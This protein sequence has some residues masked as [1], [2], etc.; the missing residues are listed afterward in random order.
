MISRCL[1][2]VIRFCLDYMAWIRSSIGCCPTDMPCFSFPMMQLRTLAL[3]PSVC[4]MISWSMAPNTKYR[5]MVFPVANSCLRGRSAVQSGQ[6]FPLRW[7]SENDAC[8]CSSQME[9][10]AHVD[11]PSSLHLPRNGQMSMIMCVSTRGMGMVDVLPGYFATGDNAGFVWRCR[12]P[13]WARCPGTAP[14]IG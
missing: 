5:S 13:D 9:R 1:V 10:R 12:G 7:A 2:L 3:C 8:H 4:C 14:S 11:D 6:H